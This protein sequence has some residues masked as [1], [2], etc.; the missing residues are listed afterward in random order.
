VSRPTTPAYYDVF[1]GLNLE[2]PSEIGNF[3]AE[4]L[5][6]LYIVNRGQE[7]QRRKGTEVLL[8]WEQ[9]AI[10]ALIDGLEW[11]R[12]NA[13]DHLIATWSGDI[14]DALSGTAVVSGGSDRVGL[15]DEVNGAVLS[16]K[17]YLGNG[18]DQNVRWNGSAIAQVMPSGAP[19]GML[20]TDGG[21]GGLTGTYS[22]KVTFLSADGLD[23]EPSEATGTYAV[24][25]KQI[26][27]TSIPTG[28]ATENV[29]GRRIW[30]IANGGS[31]YYL[32]TT[33]SN[34]T[35]TTYVD[36][37]S[38]ASLITGT[39]L[40]TETKRF[41]PCRFLANHQERLCGVYSGSSEGDTSTLYISNYQEPENCPLIAPLDEVDDPTQG[42]RIPLTSSGTA[43]ASFGNV[44]LVWTKG[45]CYRLTGDNPNNWSFD[46]WLDTG[47]VSHRTVR[48]HRNLL[49]WLAGD[50]VYLA[51]GWNNINRISD[52]I[53][54]ELDDFT[55]ASLGRAHSFIWE[56]R[57]YLCS[58]SGGFYFDLKY[59]TW[60]KVTSWPWRCSAVSRNTGALRERIFASDK[61]EVKVWE[62]ETGTDDDGTAIQ[63]VW[64]SKDKD[65]GHFGRE[66]RIH[67]V[68]A[69]F[70]TSSGDVTVNL[71]RG[72]VL[73]DAFTHDLSSVNR[74]GSVI[75]QLDDRA[76]EGARDEFFALEVDT[77]TS[78]PEFRLLRA[79]F[80]FTLCT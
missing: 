13:T 56:D 44:L 57:Y 27:I 55:A 46:K 45:T 3:E 16:E 65:L 8:D 1:G 36:N 53:R 19:S 62:L 22:Y 40:D 26:S 25:S 39:E 10:V 30:R 48:S 80:H 28:A 11:V 67:R 59:R 5:T 58:T 14:Y 38:D 60:G 75:S 41:P 72:G 79:G 35:S 20:I 76:S 42:I 61:L 33:I 24:A 64:K 77:Q 73:L 31:T 51:E 17:L 4:T 54:E 71:Y 70:V 7:L 74:T 23:S 2:S 69:G 6:N 29:T 52:P 21:A 15:W 78:A 47:C 68:I 63:A 34:N 12:I 50:G 66:K 9:E 43:I 18:L 37:L 32:V 49:L